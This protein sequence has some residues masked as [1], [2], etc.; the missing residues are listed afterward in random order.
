MAGGGPSGFDVFSFL[1]GVAGTPSDAAAQGGLKILT[2][3]AASEADASSV[4]TRAPLST[5]AAQGSSSS[6]DQRIL[7]TAYSS[8]A[9]AFAAATGSGSSGYGQTGGPRGRTLPMQ[10]RVV[11][12]VTSTNPD[13]AQPELEVPLPLKPPCTS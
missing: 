2:R 13:E 7:D 4:D 5:A 8:A 3:Q 12:D 9:N 6:V 10:E 1:K 11:Y